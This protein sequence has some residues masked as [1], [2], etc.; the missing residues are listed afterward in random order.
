MRKVTVIIVIFIT[1]TQSQIACARSLVSPMSMS[2]V[3]A[4]KHNTSSYSCYKLM[5]SINLPYSEATNTSTHFNQS[6]DDLKQTV[7][8]QIQQV[9]ERVIAGM[10]C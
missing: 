8:A 6:I 4:T 7:A 10:F 2:S 9:Q 5:I 3:L 1:I